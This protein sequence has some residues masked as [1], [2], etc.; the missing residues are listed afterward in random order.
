MVG[1]SIVIEFMIKRQVVLVTL[2][3]HWTREVPI[4]LDI[5]FFSRDTHAVYP[6]K[7]E[8]EYDDSSFNTGSL[9]TLSSDDIDEV[10]IYMKG[11][12]PEYKEKSK[13]KFRVWS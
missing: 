1:G 9:S 10:M 4:V 12:R 7:L 5:L 3:H 11:L 6:P 2:R 8:V 13:V